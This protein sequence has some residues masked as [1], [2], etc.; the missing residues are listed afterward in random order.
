MPSRPSDLTETFALLAQVDAT[1]VGFLI[2]AMVFFYGMDRGMRLRAAEV[3]IGDDIARAWR[4]GVVAVAAMLAPLIYGAA[5]A[6]AWTRWLAEVVIVLVALR[7]ARLL[8]VLFDFLGLHRADASEPEVPT[9]N[10]PRP[11]AKT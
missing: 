10:I 1:L 3:A 11:R 6:S 4:R 7:V 8:R 9:A 5:G 2:T